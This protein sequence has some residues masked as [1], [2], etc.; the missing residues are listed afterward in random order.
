MIIKKKKKTLDKYNQTGYCLHINKYGNY[1]HVPAKRT[2]IRH[3]RLDSSRMR[4]FFLDIMFV[5]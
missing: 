3:Q 5:Y 2:W 1:K 4:T